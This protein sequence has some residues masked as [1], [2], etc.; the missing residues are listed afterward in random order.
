LTTYISL[1]AALPYLD[2]FLI[3]IHPFPP[4]PAL[5]FFFLLL[6]PLLLLSFSLVGHP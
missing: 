3:S 4:L 1:I 6:L 5:F 2:D